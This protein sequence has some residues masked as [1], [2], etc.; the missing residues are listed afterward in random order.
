MTLHE[1]PTEELKR[2][3]AD[4]ALSEKKAAFAEAVLR[5]RRSERLR[6]WLGRHAWLAAAFSVISAAGILLGLRSRPK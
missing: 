4:G 2:L 6:E 3:L 5:R 1:Q